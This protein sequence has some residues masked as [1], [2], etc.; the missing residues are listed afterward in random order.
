MLGFAHIFLWHR[1]E[2][3]KKLSAESPLR[4]LHYVEHQF[5]GRMFVATSGINALGLMK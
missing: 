1:P 2:F 5:N 3:K 4:G